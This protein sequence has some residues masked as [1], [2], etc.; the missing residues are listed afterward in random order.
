MN[1]G[2]LFMA[3]TRLP[4]ILM[5]GSCRR[6]NCQLHLNDE[7]TFHSHPKIVSVELFKLKIEWRKNKKKFYVRFAVL[8]NL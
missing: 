7:H 2:F 6:Q 5:L 3:K 1:F 4:Q 8:V